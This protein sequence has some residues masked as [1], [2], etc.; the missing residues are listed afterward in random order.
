MK[1]IAWTACQLA[2][3]V[4]V[5]AGCAGKQA[6][7][8]AAPAAEEQPAQD[9]PATQDTEA[10]A[11][12]PAKNQDAEPTGEAPVKVPEQDAAEQTA[13]EE[14]ET[15]SMSINVY[16]TDPEQSELLQST[17]EIR[18]PSELQKYKQAFQALQ[19]SNND[20][21]VPLWSES[22]EIQQI[23]FENGALTFDIGLPDDARLGAG[24]ESLALE[25]LTKTMF[26]FPEVDTLDLLVDGEAV[27]SLMGHA[28][29]EHP[30]KRNN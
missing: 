17:Q 14:A 6:A 3:I 21:Q 22:I 5:T 8:P 9:A 25:A 20:G 16:Y 2:L 4:A 18:Y 27:E 30:M 23:R 24:G 7:P 15:G 10:S 28:D 12:D 1:K 13:A 29:L 11:E 26:Q 19:R